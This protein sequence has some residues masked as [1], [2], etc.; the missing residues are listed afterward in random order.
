[1]ALLKWLKNA[2]QTM[3]EPK[4]V[5]KIKNWDDMY[6]CASSRKLLSK[7]I[8]FVPIRNKQD[9]K[10]YGRIARHEKSFE[11]FTAWILIL[12]MA[13]KCPERGLLMDEEGPLTSQDLSDKSRYPVSVFDFALDFLSSSEIAWLEKIPVPEKLRIS[14]T[15]DSFL[16]LNPI[17]S[18]EI[19]LNSSRIEENGIELNKRVPKLSL[20]KTFCNENGIEESDAVYFHNLWKVNN[21]TNNNTVIYDWRALILSRQANN[22]LPSQKHGGHPSR[23]TSPEMSLGQV[24]FE[25]GKNAEKLEDLQHKHTAYTESILTPIELE[26]LKQLAKERSILNEQKNKLM[27]AQAQEN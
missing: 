1:M 4:L 7:S 23:P 13:S 2:W 24:N 11:I 10:G 18:Q 16:P 15:K 17:E 5:Y 12:Q 3:D 9:G 6:E 21:F 20:I 8:S 22:W 19:P 27:Q 14:G 26:E 25:L